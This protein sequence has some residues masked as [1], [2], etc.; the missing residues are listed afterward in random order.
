MWKKGKKKLIS[1]FS[2]INKPV[3]RGDSSSIPLNL[4]KRLNEQNVKFSCSA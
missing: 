2:V 4:T 3:L 1:S